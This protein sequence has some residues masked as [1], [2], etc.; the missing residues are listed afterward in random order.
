MYAKLL[1]FGAGAALPAPTLRVAQSGGAPLTLPLKHSFEQAFQLPLHNGYGMTEA[2]PSICQTRMEAPRADCS[3]GP[4]I[5]GIEIRLH[6]ADATGVGELW[7][8]GPNVMQGY[9]RAPEL[10]GEALTADGWLRT[11]DL[12]RIDADGAL[13]IVGR[14]KELIIRSGFNVY[15][16]EV[17]Q[18]LNAYQDVVQSAVV[19]VAVDDNEEVVAFIEPAQGAAID[20]AALRAHLAQN[21]SPYKIPGEIIVLERLPAAATGKVLKKELQRI[22]LKERAIS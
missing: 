5:P 1:E 14:S 19:G 20:R 22:A 15:P 7:V 17:E 10:S 6:D 21:L 16:I 2:S 18:V 4:A 11:G 8:R 3:V 9:Y 13:F 12:A